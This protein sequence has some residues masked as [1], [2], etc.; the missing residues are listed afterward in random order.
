MDLLVDR[1]GLR[2]QAV[3]NFISSAIGIIISLV[4]IIC[5]VQ[6]T[7]DHWIRD[8]TDPFKLMWFPKAIPI[9]IIPVGSFLLLIQFIRRIIIAWK[10]IVA[11]DKKSIEGY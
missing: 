4:F 9:A 2:G 1:L 5:G 6:V 3:F 10:G 11:R 7:V 8:I